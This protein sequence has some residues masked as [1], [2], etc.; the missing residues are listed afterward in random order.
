MRLR[1]LLFGCGVVLLAVLMSGADYFA[2]DSADA[3]DD[4]TGVQASEAAAAGLPAPAAAAR[5]AVVPPTPI[6]SESVA[7]VTCTAG[8]LDDEDGYEWAESHSVDDPAVCLSVSEPF[9]EGCRLYVEI[10]TALGHREDDRPP[11]FE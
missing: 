9:N 11:S 3:P 7:P 4:E 10:Q 5:P 2:S 1:W 8:C 6:A